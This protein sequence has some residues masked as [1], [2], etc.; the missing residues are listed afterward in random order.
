[1]RL[2]GRLDHDPDIGEAALKRLML[3]RFAQIEQML[4]GVGFMVVDDPVAAGERVNDDGSKRWARGG[5]AGQSDVRLVV[6]GRAYGV[7]VKTR[8]GRQSKKQREYQRRL[9][10]AGGVYVLA[11][12]LEQALAPV[13]QA[14]GIELS[15]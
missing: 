7:E 10:R 9:E 12:N 1:M 13:C 6:L 11:R 4:G 8:T 3:G 14:L 5:V 2:E 15:A